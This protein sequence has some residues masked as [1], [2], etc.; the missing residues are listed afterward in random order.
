MLLR[1]LWHYRGFVVGS[2]RR[3]FQARY[4]NSMLG[5][6]WVLL[7]PLAMII[8][9]T[10][11][12]S[13]LMHARLPNASSEFAYGIYLCAGLLTWGLFTE[14]V[15]RL[16]NVFLDNGNML[17]KLSFPRIC[18]P[19]ISVLNACLNFSVIFSLFIIFLLLSGNFP[20]WVFIGMVPVLLIQ[21]LFSVGLGIILGVL[22]VF[23][24]DIGQLFGI[25]VQFWFWF[26][27]IVYTLSTL[28][29]AVQPLIKYNPMASLIMAYQDIF[30]SGL[31]PNWA[32]LWPVALVSVVLCFFGMQLFRRRSGEMVDEL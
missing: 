7:N 16:Q 15:A 21:I 32:S 28:P 13:Q 27:P 31:W 17:K 22:N 25:V 1:T 11:I 24:R 6:A 30:V 12:F 8:V 4:R 19:I 2:V 26:T 14:I 29:A 9:Y 3:E 23:F 5:A 18:L 20:G 10:V